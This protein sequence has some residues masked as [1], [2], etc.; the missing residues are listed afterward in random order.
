M[1]VS[2]DRNWE[3]YLKSQEVNIR[4]ALF[5]RQ[6]APKSTPEAIAAVE[7]EYREFPLP[8]DYKQFVQKIGP[9]TLGRV[10]IYAYEIV[11][12][13]LLSFAPIDLNFALLRFSS[14]D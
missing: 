8:E 5:G 2:Q 14:P 12:P 3:D 7:K 11:S 13:E 9:G 1:A 6:S 4:P 10:R